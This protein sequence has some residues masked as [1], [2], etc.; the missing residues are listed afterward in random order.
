MS[1]TKQQGIKGEDATDRDS[2][3][4][5]P[6]NRGLVYICATDLAGNKTEAWTDGIVSDNQAPVGM[7][8]RE[9]TIRTKGENAAGFY[10]KDIPL[11]IEINDAPSQDNFSGLKRV[12]Y[13]VGKNSNQLSGE[14]TLSNNSSN[15]LSW[16]QIESMYSYSGKDLI[17]DAAQNES[18]YAAIKVTAVDNAGNLSTSTKEIKIDV[19]AP[20]INI[21]FDNNNAQ[22]QVYYNTDRTARIDITELNFDP[23]LVEL[24]IYKDGAIDGTLNAGLSNWT[25]GDNAVH[26]SYITFNQDGDYYFEVKCRDMADNESQTASSEEFTID[27]TKPVIS[28]SY[29]NDNP[30]KENYYNQPRTAIITVT[31]HNFN[32]NNFEA[33]I[34]PTGSISGWSNDGDEHRTTI[35]FGGELQYSYILSYTDLAGNQADLYGPDEFIIDSTQ[36]EIIIK[37]VEDRSANSGDINPTI[38]MRDDHFDEEGVDISLVNSKGKGINLERQ[39][40]RSENAYVY[41]FENIN[42]QPDEIYTLTATATDLAGN[43]TQTSIRFSLNREGSVYDLSQISKLSDKGYIRSNDMGDIHIKEMN[44]SSIKEFIMIVTKNDKAITGKEVNSR[45]LLKS[46]KSIYYSVSVTGNDDIGYEYDYTIYKEAFMDEGIY[47]VMFYSKDAA[48]NEVNNTLDEKAAELTFIIDNTAPSVSI[49]GI[50]EEWFI[51]EETKDVNVYINDNFKLTNGY[52][53]L[54]DEDQKVISTFDYMELAGQ[55]GDVVTITIPATEKYCSLGY[56]A[57]DAAGNEIMSL[58]ESKT[59]KAASISQALISSDKMPSIILGVMVG[60][61]I[62]LV[63]ISIKLYL[64][65]KKGCQ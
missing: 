54:V 30:W 22:N 44:I 56:Y 63:G 3:T 64:N 55:E 17:I 16:S 10:N 8:G 40:S 36:P 65:N 53:E 42:S 1:L 58:S 33:V 11:E 49:N 39:L 19:T 26:T 20:T 27:M 2:Y 47:N 21:S 7:E 18:N 13:Q 28:V 38:Y 5:S 32:P 37:G 62:L 15:N 51:L 41:S 50:D 45:P 12:T 14:I 4:I 34:V 52:F 46:S 35:Y 29:D 6:C 25:L 24:T 59:A 57:S 61:I 31:E 9:I 48:G 60:V 43:R 23:S